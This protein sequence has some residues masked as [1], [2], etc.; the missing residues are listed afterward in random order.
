M[1][2]LA[3]INNKGGVGKTTSAV[4]LAAW[5]ARMGHETLLVDFDPSAGSSLHLGFDPAA[6]SASTLCDYL[7]VRDGRLGEHIHATTVSGL[8]CLPSEPSLGEFY[9]EVQ[10]GDGVEFFLNRK[11]I[12]EKFR[13]VICDCPPNM[14]SLAFN[15]LSLADFAVVPIQTQY[16]SLPGLDLTLEV[17]DKARRRLNPSLKLLGFFGTHFDRR[18]AVAGKVLD[19]LRQ[20]LGSQMFR[21]VIGVN[22]KLIEAFQARLPVL[23]YAPRARGSEEYRQLAKEMLKRMNRIAEQKKDSPKP[24]R[25]DNEWKH[26]A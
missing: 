14:G 21:T 17:V 22:S 6:N 20:R 9:E 25:G 8:S 19:L 1:H 2:V 11:D 4:N 12:P 24:T 16:L 18:S 15:A 23:L 13:F 26:L 3:V 5:F 7:I 10:Q